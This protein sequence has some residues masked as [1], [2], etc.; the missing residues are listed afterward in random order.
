MLR[1]DALTAIAGFP[2]ALATV[3]TYGSALRL[4]VVP[5]L[6]KLV[7]RAALLRGN[8]E[9]PY[10]AY[11]WSGSRCLADYLVRWAD[12]RGR[13]VLEIGCGLGLAGAAA[14]RSGADSVFVDAALPAL[15]F[16]RASLCANG[17]AGAA[18]CAD[19]RSLSAG[20]RF[21]CI[22][23]AEV[24]YEA[25]RFGDL[26]A[27]LA[28]HLAP[29]GIALIADGFRTDTRPLYRA[30]LDHG[31]TTRALDLQ[32][33]EEGRPARVRLTEARARPHPG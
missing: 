7:D 15:A 18:A 8:V 13:P 5:D 21:D 23:A 27:T 19:Y 29:G 6:E 10:W 3:P 28:R 1:G 2:A 16:V 4:Y 17:L 24:A 22:L 30:L 9:P 20:T 32:V 31:L 33:S 26:A 11:L 14:A 25:A 12:L